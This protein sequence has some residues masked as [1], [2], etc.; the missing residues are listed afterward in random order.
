MSVRA[1][2]CGSGDAESK[3]FRD[4]AKVARV[5]SDPRYY[6]GRLRLGTAVSMMKAALAVERALP[7]LD[8][9]LLLLQ[10][11]ADEVRQPAAAQ[12]LASCCDA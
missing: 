8:T 11:T 7:L 5:H 6:R 12:Q 1:W 2:Y 4:K 9:P 10:G 3:V